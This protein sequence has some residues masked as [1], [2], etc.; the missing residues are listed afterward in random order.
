MHSWVPPQ[1]LL[2]CGVPPSLRY[3][4]DRK[5]AALDQVYKNDSKGLACAIIEHVAPAPYHAPIARRPCCE[6]ECKAQSLMGISRAGQASAIL[7]SFKG[8]GSHFIN[9]ALVA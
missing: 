7:N 2:L 5:P 4:C 1:G 9:M 3:V 8:R 6:K